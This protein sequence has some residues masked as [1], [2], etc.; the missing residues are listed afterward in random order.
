MGP[1][2]WDAHGMI[3]QAQMLHV[4]F[5]VNV[6]KYTIHLSIWEVLNPPT[7][8]GFGMFLVSGGPN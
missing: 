6:G 2:S 4:K 7:L 3:L 5:K 8:R 1:I